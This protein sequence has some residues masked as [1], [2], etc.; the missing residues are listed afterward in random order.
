MANIFWSFPKTHKQHASEQF[1]ISASGL[2]L[3]VNIKTPA[4]LKHI[5]EQEQC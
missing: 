1:N 5:L 3:L 4:D 2:T